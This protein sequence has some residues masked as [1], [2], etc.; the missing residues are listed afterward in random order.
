MFCHFNEVNS[1]LSVPIQWYINFS[2]IVSAAE[3]DKLLCVVKRWQI[4]LRNV[5]HAEASVQSCWHRLL[6]PIYGE[7]RKKSSEEVRLYRELG[8][9]EPGFLHLSRVLNHYTKGAIG[10]NSSRHL[11]IFL[12][13]F[14]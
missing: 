2:P 11:I 4:F 7:A 6:W 5:L 13:S 14:N 12:W 9:L 8:R 1:G 10:T 3:G